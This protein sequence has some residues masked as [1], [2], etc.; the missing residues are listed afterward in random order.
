MLAWL[1][2]YCLPGRAQVSAQSVG[3]MTDGRALM[4]RIA[5]APS[6]PQDGMVALYR[7]YDAHESLLYVR[8]QQ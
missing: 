6:R 8:H 1:L 4:S 5:D 2:R 7:F 3:A